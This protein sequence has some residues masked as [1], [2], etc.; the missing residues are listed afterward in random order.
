MDKFTSLS[1]KNKRT[2]SWTLNSM[3]PQMKENNNTMSSMNFW[4]MDLLLVPLL[5][6]SFFLRLAQLQEEEKILWL[7]DRDL[8]DMANHKTVSH[9]AL[10]SETRLLPTRSRSKDWK[11]WPNKP[12]K[13]RPKPWKEDAKNKSSAPTRCNCEKE[14]TPSAKTSTAT[15]T[16]TS[17][18]RPPTTASSRS[19]W[20]DQSSPCPETTTPHLLQSTQQFDDTHNFINIFSLKCASFWVKRW[21]NLTLY[22]TLTHL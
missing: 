16:P 19:Q 14:C 2:V 21:Q 11:N 18:S 12:K 1:L 17:H 10:S 22:L 15:K 6:L 13:K 8:S 5:L 20:A 3:N 7:L 4:P 9:W